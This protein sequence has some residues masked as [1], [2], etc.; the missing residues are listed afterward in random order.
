MHIFNFY[1]AVPL[2]K[3]EM[4][5]LIINSCF[6]SSTKSVEPAKEYNQ[7]NLQVWVVLYQ[8]PIFL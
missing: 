8:V 2:N 7:W 6:C 3:H 1:V 5:I 4:L